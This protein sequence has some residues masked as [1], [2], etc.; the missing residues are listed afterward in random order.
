[1]SIFAGS[2][3]VVVIASLDG[4][5]VLPIRSFEDGPGEREELV[6]LCNSSLPNPRDASLAFNPGLGLR[7][8]RDFLASES[9]LGVEIE[10]SSERVGVLD[11]CTGIKLAA[12][13][14]PE[15]MLTVSER[16]KTIRTR[17]CEGSSI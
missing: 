10:A 15:R 13:S 11:H 12:A 14:V 16:R 2:E 17:T 7:L 5:R 4:R 1:M 9:E 8:G 3:T 6:D